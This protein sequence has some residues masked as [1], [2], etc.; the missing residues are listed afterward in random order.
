MDFHNGRPRMS[1]KNSVPLTRNEINSIASSSFG[2]EKDIRFKAPPSCELEGIQHFN[3]V[4]SDMFDR[5]KENIF[6]YNSKKII[7]EKVL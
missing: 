6:E 1:M 4:S 3:E 5:V 7:K 2:V